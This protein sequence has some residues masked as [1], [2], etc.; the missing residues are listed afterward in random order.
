MSVAAAAAVNP[1]GIK[2]LLGNGLG[3]FFIKGNLVCSNGQGVYLEIILI[4]L[5]IKVEF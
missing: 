1:Y 3:T 2:T 4:A 5:F